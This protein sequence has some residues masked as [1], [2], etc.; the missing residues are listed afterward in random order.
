VGVDN[1]RQVITKKL[2]AREVIIIFWIMFISGL[3]IATPFLYREIGNILLKIK[4]SE[5]EYLQYTQARP[6]ASAVGSYGWMLLIFGY[7]LA[8]LIRIIAWSIQKSK[9]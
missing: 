1:I 8:V 7:P 6:I 2:I 9:S 4:I 3:L 5:S